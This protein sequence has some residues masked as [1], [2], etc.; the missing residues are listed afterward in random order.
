MSFPSSAIK[1]WNGVLNPRHL[2]GVRFVLRTISWISWSDVRSIS[3]WRGSHRRKRPLA[4]SMP[5]F[6]HEA[7]ASQ[8]QVVISRM[9]LSRAC[10]AK[11]G[12]LSKVDASK[13][14][15]ANRRWID[16]I[17]HGISGS[18]GHRSIRR[19]LK[20]DLDDRLAELSAKGDGLERVQALVD[21]EMFLPGARSRRS[22]RADRST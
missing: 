1:A 7:Y 21:F 11:A 22:W 9:V 19:V 20:F 17:G 12:S 5:P 6:C 3:R 8:N 13:N 4:F 2:R 18:A 14:L 10:W 16:S 15:W